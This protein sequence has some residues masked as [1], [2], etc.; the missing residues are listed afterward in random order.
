MESN[1]GKEKSQDLKDV[2]KLGKY[3]MEYAGVERA[4]YRADGRKENDAEHSEMLKMVA[5][6]LA[7]RY[8]P[9]LSIGRVALFSGIHDIPEVIVGDTPTFGI[10]DEDRKR[11][12]VQETEAAEFLIDDLP[13]PWGDV[14]KD[15]EAQ[16]EPEARFVRLVDKMMPSLTHIYGDGRTAFRVNY[17]ITNTVDFWKLRGNRAEELREQYPEFPEIHDLSDELLAH[18]VSIMWPEDKNTEVQ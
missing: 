11:K 9:E 13:V 17:G 10:S 4:T 5:V 16:E 15:Y 1:A 8:Y 12:E 7:T 2:L 18:A 14:L 3:A 6:H